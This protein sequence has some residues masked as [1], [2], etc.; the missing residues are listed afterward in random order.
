[1]HPDHGGETADFIRLRQAYDQIVNELAQEP[2]GLEDCVVGGRYRR[3]D[4]HGRKPDSN[5]EPELIVL[6]EP[7]RGFARSGRPDPTGSPI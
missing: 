1:M 3:S 6:D 4:R 2:T 5:W 7:L